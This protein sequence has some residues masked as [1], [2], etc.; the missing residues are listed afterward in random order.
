MSGAVDSAYEMPFTLD[1]A[2]RLFFGG[3]VTPATLRA[4]A[5]RGRLV[6]ERIGPAQQ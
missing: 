3:K 5:R 4:E 1:E 6:I 2:C